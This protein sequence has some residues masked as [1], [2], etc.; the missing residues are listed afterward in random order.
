MDAVGRADRDAWLACFAPD[1]V[2]HDPVGGSPLDPEGRGLQGHAA[3]QG[4]WDLTIAPG[5]VAF[6]IAS[7]HP[8]GP[9]EAAVV[10]TVTARL[11]NGATISYDGVFVYAVDRAGAITTLRAYWDVERVLAA[12][13]S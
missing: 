9:D 11:A 6:A 5:T 4:F 12:A 7:V 10:A 13:L 3:L 8:G 1:A 2:V